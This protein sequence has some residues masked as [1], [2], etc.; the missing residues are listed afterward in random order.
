MKTELKIELQIPA[1]HPCY[2]DH[3]PDRTIVPGTVL[4][5]YVLD[6]CD[7]HGFRANTIKSCKFQ[8][9]VVPGQELHLVLDSSGIRR[10][11]RLEDEARTYLLAT[12]IAD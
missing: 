7:A 1:E 9:V 3:F 6:A 4:L 11:V 2:A 12:L 5:Q 10:N 8:H